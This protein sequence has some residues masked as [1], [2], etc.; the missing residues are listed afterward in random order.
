MKGSIGLRGQILGVILSVILLTTL[1]GVVF[2]MAYHRNTLYAQTVRELDASSGDILTTMHREVHDTIQILWV[3][4]SRDLVKNGCS[5]RNAE[6]RRYF[7]D[8]AQQAG[9]HIS[10]AELADRN[11][12]I[13]ASSNEDRVDMHIEDLTV[14]DAF[15]KGEEVVISS[16]R[17]NGPVAY[18][19][20]ELRIV[21]DQGQFNG[22]LRVR[23][24][25]GKKIQRTFDRMEREIGS[26]PVLIDEHGIIRMAPAQLSALPGTRNGELLGSTPSV[27]LM[28][29]DYVMG[30]AESIGY[31]SYIGHPWRLVLLKES[32]IALAPIHAFMSYFLIFMIVIGGLFMLFGWLAAGRLLRPIDRLI[33]FASGIGASGDIDR[34]LAVTHNDEVGQL[35]MS[36]NQML[37]RL[38]ANQAKIQASEERNSTMLEVASALGEGFIIIQEHSGWPWQIFDWNSAA[39]SML[40]LQVEPEGLPSLTDFLPYDDNIL[41]YLQFTALRQNLLTRVPPLTVKMHHGNGAVFTVELSAALSDYQGAP[42]LVVIFRD[43]TERYQMQQQLIQA[44][45]MEALG[46]MAGGFVH[47]FNNLLAAL[48]GYITLLKNKIASQ[49][50]G[51]YVHE[52]ERIALR[53]ADMVKNML[54]FSRNKPPTN[55]QVSLTDVVDEVRRLVQSSL[56]QTVAIE[57]EGCLDFQIRGDQS[58]LVQVFLNLLLNASDAIQVSNTPD[59]VIKLRCAPYAHKETMASMGLPFSTSS[60]VLVEVEDNGIGMDEEVRQRLF[61]P[62]FTTKGERGTGMGLAITYRIIK[63]HGG[64]ILVESTPGKG[65]IFKIFLPLGAPSATDSQ[66]IPVLTAESADVQGR[67]LLIVDDEVAIRK[68]VADMLSTRGYAVDT[69]ADGLEALDK[70]R[71]TEFDAIILDLTM[72]QMD[73]YTFM[74]RLLAFRPD[75]KIIVAS[76]NID[77]K[78]GDDRLSKARALMPKPFDLPTITSTL[79]K[80][81]RE[82]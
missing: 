38:Q 52:L 76:G 58:Q 62:F 33:A 69:A 26:L 44:Q 59:G 45:K 53:G 27:T 48:L 78:A 55:R 75:A 31:R 74:E 4:A 63:N 22:V 25:Y 43:V 7:A 3:I 81:L 24:E 9:Y 50:A 32:A 70:C 13:C 6:L 65:S 34:R 37:T 5:V 15:Q 42:S 40:S 67:H 68:P 20:M 80:V 64:E 2:Q 35:T 12:R 8:V 21:S 73:G 39:Q 10:L 18:M 71:K 57:V 77:E 14:L 49:P 16:L 36:F 79:D 29:T 23:F 46:T 17:D 28:G 66:S 51:T 1:A 72:P 19:T 47:D 61:E 30:H 41:L 82:P 60:Y 54:V 11:G 56:K